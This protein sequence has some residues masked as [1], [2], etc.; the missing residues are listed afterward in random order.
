MLHTLRSNLSRHTF[1]KET[2]QEQIS[3]Q[4]PWGSTLSKKSDLYWIKEENS[5]GLDMSFPE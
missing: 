2:P 3:H 5:P 1:F 4:S